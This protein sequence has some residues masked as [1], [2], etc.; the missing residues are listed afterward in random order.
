MTQA[1]VARHG[2]LSVFSAAGLEFAVAALGL[3]L[4]LGL[5]RLYI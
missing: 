2:L 1:D 5:A 3:E 4:G